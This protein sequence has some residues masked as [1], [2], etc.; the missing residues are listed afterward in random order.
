MN[1]A[2]SIDERLVRTTRKE[3]RCCECGVQ[4]PVGSTC[5]TARGLWEDGPAEYYW[6]LLCHMVRH[7][8]LAMLDW[9]DEPLGYGEL[10]D[11]VRDIR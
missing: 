2:I 7:E 5:Y 4:M 1:N 11:Y 8:V 6:C 9:R 10:Y 3:H